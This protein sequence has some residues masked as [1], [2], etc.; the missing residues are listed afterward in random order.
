MGLSPNADGTLS[1]GLGVQGNPGKGP[2][3]GAP[4]KGAKSARR[5]VSDLFF[6][7]DTGASFLRR[8]EPSH[9]PLLSE[10][11]KYSPHEAVLGVAAF[12]QD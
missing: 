2:G 9:E 10:R 3:Y 6:D 4:F 1:P 5:S 11:S 8:A 12:E 7:E